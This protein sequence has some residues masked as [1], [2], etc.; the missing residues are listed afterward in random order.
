MYLLRAGLTTLSHL[1]RVFVFTHIA[2]SALQ[3]VFMRSI[4]CG[5]CTGYLCLFPPLLE[6]STKLLCTHLHMHY[7]AFEFIQLQQAERSP[8]HC[9]LFR[10]LLAGDW[11]LPNM[12]KSWFTVYSLTIN[13]HF[14]HSSLQGCRAIFWHFWATVCLT[15]DCC[16][17][18]IIR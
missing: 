18:I 15:I 11:L 14:H 1:T 3:L 17:S 4:G 16:Q 7:S 12:W 13:T 10:Y 9:R 2:E 8:W 5:V 6:M